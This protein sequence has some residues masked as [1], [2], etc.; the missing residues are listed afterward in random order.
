MEKLGTGKSSVPSFGDDRKKWVVK[1]SKPKS[2][3]SSL[4][5]TIITGKVGEVQ[6][7]SEQNRVIEQAQDALR[8]CGYVS[9]SPESDSSTMLALSI[10]LSTS[11]AAVIRLDRNLK[12]ISYSERPLSWVHATL[13]HGGRSQIHS[14]ERAAVNATPSISQ[15]DVRNDYDKNDVRGKSQS[16]HEGDSN[17]SGNN[18]K[19][20]YHCVDRGIDCIDEYMKDGNND[21]NSKCNN[22]IKESDNRRTNSNNMTSNND[23]DKTAI[24]ANPLCILRDHDLRFMLSTSEPIDSNDPAYKLFYPSGE[25]L[26]PVSIIT[27]QPVRNGTHISKEAFAKISYVRFS[28]ECIPMTFLPTQSTVAFKAQ[29]TRGTIHEAQKL[30]TQSNFIDLSLHADC[31]VLI[32]FLNG[33][34]HDNTV[35]H[36]WA[37]DVARHGLAISKSLKSIKDIK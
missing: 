2:I 18:G 9:N 5:P 7:L 4:Y 15:K 31:K 16:A 12:L 21:D 26:S 33:G 17:N 29:I 23:K 1:S 28:H 3:S 19:R 22:G 35:V 30:A 25:T 11:Y 14:M 10:T 8:S 37:A 24:N 32:D 13:C 27:G 6:N 34:R 20:G 36:Q